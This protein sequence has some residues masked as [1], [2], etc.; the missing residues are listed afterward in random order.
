RA[1]LLQH[2]AGRGS[3]PTPEPAAVPQARGLG[4]PAVVTNAEKQRRKR[5]RRNLGLRCYRVECDALDLAAL[6][7][8]HGLVGADELT[9]QV[10]LE[11]GLSALVAAIVEPGATPVTGVL[12]S[13]AIG[14]LRGTAHCEAR[15]WKRQQP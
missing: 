15:R 9:D 1:A 10:A 13:R 6:L 8:A 4:E 7:S 12:A 3:T 11:R 14:P 5:M 2:L